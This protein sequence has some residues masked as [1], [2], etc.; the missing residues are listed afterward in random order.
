MTLS[1]V[2]FRL[3]TH[4]GIRLITEKELGAYANGIGLPDVAKDRYSWLFVMDLL[5]FQEGNGVDPHMIVHEIQALEGLGP[6]HGTKAPAQFTRHP[7]KGLWHKHF[8]SAHF[9]AR[10]IRNELVGGR[11]EQIF[12][13]VCD[14]NKSPVLTEGMIK[15]LAHRITIG[16]FD[17]RNKD[18]RLTGEWIVF[19]RHEE[20]NYYLCLSTHNAGDQTI[21]DRI[22][23][24]C[25]PQFP[26]LV[27]NGVNEPNK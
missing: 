10:N 11:F 12:A 1:K 4:N 9:L 24:V 2:T 18:G 5:L 27:E 22:R 20:K 13:E 19:A 7:L 15:E 8:F 25:F 16:E 3:Q 17:N 26:F 14:P 6:K 23:D 21:Y